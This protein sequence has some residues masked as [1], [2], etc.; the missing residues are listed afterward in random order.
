MIYIPDTHALVWYFATDPRLGQNAL[1]ALREPAQ[2]L[3]IP[4]IVLAEIRYLTA[5]RRT[6]LT[7]EETL[8]RIRSALRGQI[9]PLDEEIVEAMP[10]TL[11]IHDAIICATASVY[12]HRL[13]DSVVVNTRDASIT[14]SGL[15]QVVW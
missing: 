2:Q 10:P 8:R 7:F 6:P 1:L 9:V 11:E 4:T 14:S 3:V 15:V 12:R 13:R 5:H